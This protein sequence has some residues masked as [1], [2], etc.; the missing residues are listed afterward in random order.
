MEK[1]ATERPGQWYPLSKSSGPAEDD[2]LRSLFLAHSR[3]ACRCSDLFTEARLEY[4]LL[5][6]FPD[7]L[8]MGWR[9]VRW[10]AVD[11]GCV[12]VRLA[13][14]MAWQEWS[15][16]IRRKKSVCGKNPFVDGRNPV[17]I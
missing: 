9:N 16:R 13:R 8:S 14:R 11:S 12:R 3:I 1:T 17:G 15:W 7:W 6:I 5:G 10:G 4:V 2:N